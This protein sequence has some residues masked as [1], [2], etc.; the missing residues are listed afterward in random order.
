L[1]A[2]S[3]GAVYAVVADGGRSLYVADGVN[4][5]DYAYDLTQAVA[6]R[7]GVTEAS[8]ARARALI[9]ADI[10]RLGRMYQYDSAP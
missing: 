4:D 10:D 8:R 3:Y 6:V 1:L 2:S 7:V 5:R 9:Q